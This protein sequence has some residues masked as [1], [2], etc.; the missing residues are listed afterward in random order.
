M[1]AYY[2]FCVTWMSQ[3]TQKPSPHF[4]DAW[5][6]MGELTLD[7]TT[8]CGHVLIKW[9]HVIPSNNWKCYTCLVRAVITHCCPWPDFGAKRYAGRTSVKASVIN[10][11]SCLCHRPWSG[12]TLFRSMWIDLSTDSLVTIWWNL[13]AHG[14]NHYYSWNHM[15]NKINECMYNNN[16]IVPNTLPQLT[17]IVVNQSCLGKSIQS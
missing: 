3:V 14:S 1:T 7:T 12:E 10:N 4:E 6:W 16:I 11:L 5:I 9:Y 2:S 13:F 17:S 8:K 15:I